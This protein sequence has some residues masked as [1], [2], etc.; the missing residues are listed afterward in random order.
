LSDAPSDAPRRAA[1]W[2]GL[3][4]L[5]ALLVYTALVH[6]GVGPARPGH[7]G[8][9]YTPTSFLTESEFTYAMIDPP[10]LAFVSL[11]V[12]ALLLCIGVLLTSRSA[13]VAAIAISCV[14][15]TLLFT[16]YGVVAPFPWRFF[17]ARGSAVLVLIGLT[18]GFALAAPRLARSWLALSWPVRALVYLPFVLFVIAFLR[19]ATG[20]DPSLPFAISPW[21]A[22]PVFGM[23]VGVLFV[24]IGWIGT[25]VGLLGIARSAGSRG[26]MALAIAAGV[27][28]PVLLLGIGGS[29]HLFPFHVGPRVVVAL[30]AACL[31]SIAIAASAQVRRLPDV[32]AARQA[33]ARRIGV[34]AALLGIPL[35]VGQAWAYL[36][37]YRTREVRARE[38][39]DALASYLDRESLYP[40]EL[41]ELVA[42]GDLEEIPE[43]AIGFDFLYDGHFDYQS[44]GTSYLMEFPAPRWVQCAYT[45]AALYEEYEDEDLEAEDLTEEELGESW[46]CP[47]RPPELW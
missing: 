47:S 17:G 5:A 13:L 29:L 27:G 7:E 20:T 14:V 15:T 37:Y 43:P 12:P 22:V 45:P 21:P 31:L 1:S 38:I 9:W 42:A 3:A 33:R 26:R 24:A 6:H 18:V 32:A 25:A 28:L 40:D 34:G 35:V 36:D 8:E 2:P 23:E 11:S 41:D 44:F 4:L 46:S 30:G 10:G 39:I 16:F 19:N